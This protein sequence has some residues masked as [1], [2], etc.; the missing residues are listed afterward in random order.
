MQEAA[1]RAGR[2]LQEYRVKQ[3]RL[4]REEI[5]I[6]LLQTLFASRAAAEASLMPARRV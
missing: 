6:D 1:E 3:H 5:T 4:R 2:M